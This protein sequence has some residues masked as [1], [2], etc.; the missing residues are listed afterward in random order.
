MICFGTGDTNEI[1]RRYL[2]SILITQ[3]LID[4]GLPSLKTVIFGR[5]YS[6]PVM[7]PAFSHLRAPVKD[8]KSGLVAYSRAAKELG[9]LNWVGMED[10]DSFAEVLAAGGDTV[11]IIKPYADK[12]RIFD[13]IEFAREKG[14]AAVGIDI[15]H[16]FRN[17]GYD[18]VDGME[19]SR[20]T[21]E[22]IGRYVAAAAGLPFVIKGVLS[23]EDAVKC[24]ECGVSGIVVSHHHG[25]MP[26]AVPPLM[27]LPE[28]KAA[29]AGS[30]TEIFVDCHMDSG[31][32]VFKALALGAKAASV[33]RA[34]LERIN[35]E[36]YAGAREKLE[37]M[38]GELMMVMGSTGC[39]SVEEIDS[40][41]LR[42][43]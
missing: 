20:V 9:L 1:T 14:A 8:E 36:G 39:A 5:E 43:L 10:N 33:G 13:Q 38:N 31:A 40:G 2:D 6:S 16:V 37:S 34:L 17:G 11:R 29:L 30:D 15:D 41:L 22:D 19:M 7:T 25:R 27:V 42:N 26:S 35:A 4:A 21:T 32:D 12:D 24:V 18:V 3:R 28:I 23:V